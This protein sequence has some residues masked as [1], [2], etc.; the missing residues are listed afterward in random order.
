MSFWER[1]AGFLII[2]LCNKIIIFQAGLGRTGTLIG[3][4]LIKHYDMGAR[5]SIAWLRIC[6][7]GSVIGPQQTYLEQAE[8]WLWKEGYN[9]RL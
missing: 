4:F 7:P 2:V 9:F 3:A 5:E 8:G 6:R 1:S